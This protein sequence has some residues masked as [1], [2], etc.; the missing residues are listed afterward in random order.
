MNQPGGIGYLPGVTKPR[1]AAGL[2]KDVAPGVEA[3]AGDGV[4]AVV[5]HGHRG[6]QAIVV[7]IARI[8]REPS[9]S[10]IVI[11][12]LQN[13]LILPCYNART[14]SVSPR[15]DPVPP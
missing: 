1:C 7:I 8:G 5:A 15:T 9:G 11:C 2:G 6:A 14:D 12:R 10:I 3:G 4:A 13:E